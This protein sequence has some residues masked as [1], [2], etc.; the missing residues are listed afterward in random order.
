MADIE[1]AFAAVG[2]RGGLWVLP[3]FFGGDAQGR[4]LPWAAAART[5]ARPRRRR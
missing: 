5:T 3:G 2:G 1:A 4:I